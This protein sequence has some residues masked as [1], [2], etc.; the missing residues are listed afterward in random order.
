MKRELKKYIQDHFSMVGEEH[1]LI[2]KFDG[3]IILIKDNDHF[4]GWK[5]VTKEGDNIVY[6][7][8]P[9]FD[10]LFIN[11]LI[12]DM[13]EQLMRGVDRKSIKII[14]APKEIRYTLE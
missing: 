12:E 10:D 4:G 9:N 3:E 8:M 2:V 13:A 5:Y 7:M 14:N 6:N 1:G 11:L